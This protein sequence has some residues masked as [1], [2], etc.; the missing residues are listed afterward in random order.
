MVVLAALALGGE[1]ETRPSGAVSSGDARDAASGP[2]G[3]A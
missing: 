1:R 3:W 2:G